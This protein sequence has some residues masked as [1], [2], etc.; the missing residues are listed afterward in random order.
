M[1]IVSCYIRLNKL[2][3]KLKAGNYLLT[4]EM[5][6]KE[7]T[8]V[9]IKGVSIQK[10]FTVPE[11][12]TIWQIAELMEKRKYMSEEQFWKIALKKI[13]LNMISLRT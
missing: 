11:G 2:D 5:S 1:K 4:D 7:I 12:Y 9:I 13:F 10:R 8:D 6:V 3:S